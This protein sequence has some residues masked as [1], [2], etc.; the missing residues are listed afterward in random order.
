MLILGVILPKF[1]VAIFASGEGSNA[2]NLWSIAKESGHPVK[3]LICDRP[4]AR[5]IERAKND[6]V[7]VAVIDR[8][9]PDYE[10]LILKT[11]REWDIN[12]IFLAGFMS[13]LSPKCLKPFYHADKNRFQIINIHPSLLPEY[14]GIHSYQKAYAD[15]KEVHGI[16]VHYIDEG[17]DSG[18]IIEQRSFAVDKTWTLEQFI[19]FGKKVEHELYRKVF[20]NFLKEALE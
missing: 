13:I 17:I 12:W 7:K 8:K 2:Q 10:Q 6:N 4:N 16:T 11:C 15:K 14:P 20:L 9:S 1:N 5:V 19:E 3:G 18:P